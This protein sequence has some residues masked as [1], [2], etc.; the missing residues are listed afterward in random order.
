MERSAKSMGLRS[1]AVFFILLLGLGGCASISV[2]NYV[3]DEYPYKKTFYASFDET[4][5][6]VKEMFDE[7]HW[8]VS[9]TSDPKLYERNKTTAVDDTGKQV[10]IFSDLRTTPLGLGTRYS[11]VNVYLRTVQGSETE[12]EIRYVTV[13]SVPFKTF[14]DF[15]HN[16]TVEA[17]LKSISEK[18]DL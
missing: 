2:P 4:F 16:K 1:S 18:L 12:V 17:M 5:E 7:F 8:K 9:Q 13:S 6:A 14:Y 10:L 15:K 3:K 11:R